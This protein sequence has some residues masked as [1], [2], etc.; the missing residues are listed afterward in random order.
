MEVKMDVSSIASVATSMSQVKN[1]DDVS[2][3][4]FKKALDT[5]SSTAMQLIEALPPVTNL[6]AHLGQNINTTA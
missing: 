5:A 3:A 1:A 4:V 6:P 2:M